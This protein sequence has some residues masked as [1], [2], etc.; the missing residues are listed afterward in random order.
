MS[1]NF[2]LE[3]LIAVCMVVSG[4][5]GQQ[6]PSAPR[7]LSETSFDNDL[8]P[9]FS[10]HAQITLEWSPPE[11]GIVQYLNVHGLRK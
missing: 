8:R 11:N 7:N 1:L 6:I 5:G 4:G 3:V 2:V 10:G 9:G